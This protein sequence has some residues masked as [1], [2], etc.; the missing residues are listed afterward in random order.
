MTPKNKG[1]TVSHCL[2]RSAVYQNPIQSLTLATSFTGR[3]AKPSLI[4]LSRKRPKNYFNSFM[5][6]ASTSSNTWNTS[7]C[8][9]GLTTLWLVSSWKWSH[10]RQLSCMEKSNIKSSRRSPDTNAC[11]KTIIMIRQNLKTDQAPK[12]TWTSQPYTLRIS[13]YHPSRWLEKT[14]SRY[15]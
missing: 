12:L 2:R 3:S 14:T 10:L 13:I 9:G 6:D 4:N 7:C 15:L 5:R 8:V 11:H 1:S